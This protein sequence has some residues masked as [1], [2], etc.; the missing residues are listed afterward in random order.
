[1]DCWA[2]A[3]DPGGMAT[4]KRAIEHADQFFNCGLAG[5]AV[6]GCNYGGADLWL[7]AAGPSGPG[8]LG[9]P[10]SAGLQPAIYSERPEACHSPCQLVDHCVGRRLDS[11]DALAD[12]QY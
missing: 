8:S 1:M 7:L 12:C 3:W 10:V 4:R 9:C 11:L 2:A 6:P 5:A